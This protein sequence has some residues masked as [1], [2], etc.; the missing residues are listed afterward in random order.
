MEIKLNRWTKSDIFSPEILEKVYNDGSC[1]FCHF[2]HPWETNG[3][4]PGCPSGFLG[5]HE[6]YY[7]RG[8]YDLIKGIHEGIINEPTETLL[9][10]VYSCNGCGQ[11][12]YVCPSLEKL[13]KPNEIIEEFKTILVDLGWGPLERHKRI[14][15]DIREYGNPYGEN[16][17]E[18]EEWMRGKLKNKKKG[19][20][21]FYAGC[22]GALREKQMVIATAQVLE[23]FGVDFAVLGRDE[24]CC[25]SVLL[26]T[27]QRDVAIETAEK[28]LKAIDSTG[29][30]TLITAC[31]GCFM[32]MSKDYPRVLKSGMNDDLKIMHITQFLAQKLKEIEF[33]PFKGN[34]VVAYHD[35]CHLGRH[36][37]VIEEPRK[38]L[39]AIPDLKYVEL[40]RSKMNS[41]CCGSGGGV[42]AGF[43]DKSIKVANER[44]REIKE[45]GANAIVTVC[46]F[47]ERNF[48]D[49]T[50]EIEVID[51]VDLVN[52][53]L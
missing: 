42:K 52:K 12:G 23:K 2:T 25:G 29:A 47:C 7:P 45:C 13:P 8:M 21:L 28:N 14:A 37:G 10:I 16:P 50:N 41:F 19:D 48:R 40:E 5:F 1:N 3:P 38:I 44:I 33:K 31:P 32:T 4:L 49:A 46:P 53:L 17:V 11:C 22:T 18:K 34:H 9:E 26:R 24:V 27:G 43:P 30:Q 15:E 20:V 39:R 6:S 35:P 36:G 51:L